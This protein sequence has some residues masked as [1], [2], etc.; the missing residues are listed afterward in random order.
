MGLHWQSE[1]GTSS[2]TE[3]GQR[4]GGMQVCTYVQYVCT[5]HKCVNIRTYDHKRSVV[6]TTCTG[7]LPRAERIGLLSINTVVL[8]CCLPILP[9]INGTEHSTRSMDKDTSLSAPQISIPS[10][11]A[12]VVIVILL[13]TILLLPRLS[14]SLTLS[15]LSSTMDVCR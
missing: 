9:Q 6:L 8:Y 15:A 10:L 14:S 5:E 3:G 13:Y 2:S 1:E 4:K 11:F 12:V 7:V